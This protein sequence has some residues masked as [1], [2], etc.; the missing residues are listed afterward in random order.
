MIEFLMTLYIV[1]L[2]LSAITTLT[3]QKE[4]IIAIGL[5][6]SSMS[7]YMESGLFILMLYNNIN[8]DFEKEFQIVF[9][10]NYLIFK[11]CKDRKVRSQIK[12]ITFLQIFSIPLYS[13]PK[14]TY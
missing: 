7:T 8:I 1:H 9:Y 12:V 14:T 6:L 4:F 13:S 11:V 10:K 5:A 2:F 3:T